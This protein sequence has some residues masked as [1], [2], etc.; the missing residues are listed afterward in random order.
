VCI[1][2]HNQTL[3]ADSTISS[4]FSAELLIFVFSSVHLLQGNLDRL[5]TRNAA[6]VAS[7]ATMCF[8]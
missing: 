4:V 5:L 7:R 2:C 3:P 8:A 1:G 6:V